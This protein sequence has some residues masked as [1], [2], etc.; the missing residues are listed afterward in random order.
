MVNL[1]K[2][3]VQKKNDNKNAIRLENPDDYKRTDGTNVTSCFGYG[4]DGM[5]RVKKNKGE[6]IVVRMNLLCDTIRRYST[7]AVDHSMKSIEQVHLF[8]DGHP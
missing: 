5:C 2:E 1:R 6:E 4:K 7:S 8:F 3:V